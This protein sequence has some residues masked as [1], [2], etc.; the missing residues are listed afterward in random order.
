[1]SN[2]ILQPE[3]LW[4]REQVLQRPSP[5]PALP[6]L[7]GWYFKDLPSEELPVDHC[8]AHKGLV[9]LYAGIGPRATPQGGT[10][11]RQTLRSR[12]HTH[13]RGNAS[14][15]TLRRSLGC[16]LGL[17]LRETG[18]SRRWTFADDEQRLNDWMHQNAL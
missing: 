13:Y 16:L 12:I 1:M 7:Y 3:Q 10:P 15:S 4:T 9:L 11:S 8:A 18:P 14:S 17:R 2:D 5:V 6:G